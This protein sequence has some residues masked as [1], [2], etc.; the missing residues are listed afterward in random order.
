MDNYS[1]DLNLPKASSYSLL[2]MN[3]ENNA[4]T[5]YK[6]IQNTSI[7]NAKKNAVQAFPPAKT[8]QP[9]K[10]INNQTKNV[11]LKA[12]VEA[13]PIISNNLSQ[14]I[15]QN[16]KHLSQKAN[17]SIEDTNS[18]TNFSETPPVISENLIK[19]MNQQAKVDHST[20]DIK[21]S[22]KNI[23]MAPKAKLRLIE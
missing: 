18:P 22:K 10:K 19:K 17:H 21:N 15:N 11:P 7:G 5:E 12:N 6:P 16:E 20:E 14:K 1:E 4:S 23:N 13:T 9:I 8:D 2:S 3:Q